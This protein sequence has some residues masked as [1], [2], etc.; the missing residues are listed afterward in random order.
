MRLA[1][2]LLIGLAARAASVG[3]AK[4]HLLVAGGGTLGPEIVNRFLELAG[5]PDGLIVYIPTAD[6]RNEFPADFAKT[7][8]L[9]KAGARNIVVLHTRDKALAD[10]PQFAEPLKRAR[11]VWFAGGRQ[12]RLVDS[13][14]GTRVH[15]ELD[16]L[17]KRGGVIG[18]TSAGATIQGSF[19]VRG[20]RSGNTIM[21][22]PT[23]R[24]GMGFLKNVAIDQHLLARQ[25]EKDLTGVVRDYPKLLGIGIDES[26]AILVQGDRF[27]VIGKSKVAIYEPGKEYYFLGTGDRFDLK[28]R[29][30]Q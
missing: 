22:D 19:L 29:R 3:P 24:T 2:F 25:R 14:L 16:A 17:L 12:W 18:G 30:K 1:A 6:E 10:T 4:G 15:R 8:F 5:G 9:A 21:V 20:A 27:E 23:Y 13:Y 7:N 26:T 28:K 11:G